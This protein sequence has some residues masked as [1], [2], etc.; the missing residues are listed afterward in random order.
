MLLGRST[1]EDCW[2]HPGRISRR[3]GETGCRSYIA[4]T[5]SSPSCS[6]MGLV[7]T[8]LLLVQ[9]ADTQLI[10]LPH[11]HCSLSL[12]PLSFLGLGA[13]GRCSFCHSLSEL[14]LFMSPSLLFKRFWLKR[15]DVCVW[16]IRS[17]VW[18]LTARKAGEKK[19]VTFLAFNVEGRLF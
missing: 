9:G 3:A 18:T 16:E 11:W 4:K 2:Y 12:E 10:W 15:S 5:V 6:F 17:C 14:S 8:G 1:L 13:W 19:Y 7:K